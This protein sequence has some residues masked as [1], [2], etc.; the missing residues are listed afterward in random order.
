MIKVISN[1]QVRLIDKQTIERQGISSDDLM[2]KAAKACAERLLESFEP[3]ISF[4]I[5]CGKGN[6][7][8]DGLAIARILWQRG[9]TVSVYI[10]EDTG[11]ASAD[12]QL[13]FQRLTELKRSCC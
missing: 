2:E 5:F 3:G 11:T 4:A 1:E 7:G 8:G 13:N 10:V 6:N 9:K 12:F